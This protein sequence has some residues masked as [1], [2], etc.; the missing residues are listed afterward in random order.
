MTCSGLARWE[1]RAP[2]HGHRRAEGHYTHSAGMWEKCMS[3]FF[4]SAPAGKTFLTFP[5]RK[6][7]ITHEESGCKPNIRRLLETQVKTR[8][9]RSWLSQSPLHVLLPT[10]LSILPVFVM[11]FLHLKPEVWAQIPPR[12]CSFPSIS[13]PG[14]LYFCYS[15]KRA[16]LHYRLWCIFSQYMQTLAIAFVADTVEAT[17]GWWWW[18]WCV[19][20][21]S[22]YV[23]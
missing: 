7:L 1:P 11:L 19:C 14:A 17:E 3:F 12:K 20:G 23:E 13:S 5:R 15:S 18:W 9:Q 8:W 2:Q 10:L 4:C 22:A 16:S 21:E 6:C